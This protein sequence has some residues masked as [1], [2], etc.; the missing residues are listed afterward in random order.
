MQPGT[1]A[2]LIPAIASTA[3][4]AG[5]STRIVLFRDWG[6]ERKQIR[7]AGVLKAEGLAVVGKHGVGKVVAFTIGNVSTSSFIYSGIR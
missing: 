1:G 3:W 7:L 2:A 6:W 4:D 5:I